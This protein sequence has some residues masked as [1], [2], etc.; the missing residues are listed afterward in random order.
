MEFFSVDWN[1]LK[2]FI[3]WFGLF[4]AL[5]VLLGGLAFAFYLIID[6][7]N[8]RRS[9]FPAFLIVVLTNVWA[10]IVI[11]TTRWLAG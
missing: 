2:A 5:I 7:T 11:Q 6:L 8:I 1:L 10:V 3:F 9:L 4:D